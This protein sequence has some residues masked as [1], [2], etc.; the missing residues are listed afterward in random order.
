MGCV[1]QVRARAHNLGDD[2]RYFRCL[3]FIRE[4]GENESQY[5]CGLSNVN[6]RSIGI[7]QA[8]ISDSESEVDEDDQADQTPSLVGLNNSAE[9]TSLQELRRSIPQWTGA[10]CFGN[11]V[12]ELIQRAGTRG[13]TT[14]V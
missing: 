14:M 7:D 5:L 2:Y 3:K 12:Y 13:V 1:K 10:G 9:K 8:D 4:P 11:F 6:L